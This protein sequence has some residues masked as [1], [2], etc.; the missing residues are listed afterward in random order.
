[1]KITQ[2]ESPML[3]P[4]RGPLKFTAQRGEGEQGGRSSRAS[5]WQRGDR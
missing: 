5:A 3:T 4:L 1:M 2:P